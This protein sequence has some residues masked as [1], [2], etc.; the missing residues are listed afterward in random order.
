[1]FQ[2]VWT[3]LNTNMSIIFPENTSTE[4]K[5]QIYPLFMELFVIAY[6]LNEEQFKDLKVKA[7]IE[8]WQRVPMEL[9]EPA[10]RIALEISNAIL[11]DNR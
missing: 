6:N 4:A 5:L 8:D 11:D 7:K 1:M 2:L 3:L 9:V 10:Y